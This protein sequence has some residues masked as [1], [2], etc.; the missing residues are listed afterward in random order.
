MELLDKKIKISEIALDP[1]NPR[2]NTFAIKNQTEI[3]NST[4]KK[5]E[6]KELLRSMI[7]CIRW[8][9]KIVVVTYN[10]YKKLHP[11]IEL[12]DYTYIV[13][14][15]NTRLSCLK[16]GKIPNMNSDTE[17]PVLLTERGKNE[18]IEEFRESILI[19]QGIANVTEVKPWSDIS[20]AKHIYDMYVLKIKNLKEPKN[21]QNNQLVIKSISE[22]LGLSQEDIKKNI[23][24]YTI[25]SKIEE[26]SEQIPDDK[27]GFLEALEINS[28]TRDFIGLSATYDWDE[29]KAETALSIM[30]EL[31]KNESKFDPNSKHFRDNFRT[32]IDECKSKNVEHQDIVDSFNEIIN[33][34]EERSFTEF[35]TQKEVKEDNK[36]KWEKFLED[37]ESKL[38]SYPINE[39]WAVEQIS[40]LESLNKKISKLV[41]QIKLANEE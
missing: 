38:K 25:Y 14:E 16:S 34:K 35:I 41:N 21:N 22:Q 33:S 15:G 9:N 37:S 12:S 3:L 4:M 5:Q 19:T 20:K 27:W 17:I 29:E 26:V 39:D 36:S 18:S 2:D 6:A 40:L 31:F 11:E 1:L 23:R 32:Y 8:I 13:V 24:R 7:E 28:D 30:P 10:D